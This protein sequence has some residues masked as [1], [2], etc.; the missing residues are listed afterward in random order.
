MLLRWV[1]VF[2]GILQ[3]ILKPVLGPADRFVDNLAIDTNEALWAAG[4]ADGFA[5]MSA[6]NDLEKVSPSAAFRITKNVGNEA[7]FGE[8]LKVE[9]VRRRT[10]LVWRKQ[11][12][13]DILSENRYSKMMETRL[14]ERRLLFTMLSATSFSCRVSQLR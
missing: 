6:F 7:F 8:K 11:R 2:A 9:K 12:L 1:G 10:P 4:V 3:R 5:F 14:L 13:S